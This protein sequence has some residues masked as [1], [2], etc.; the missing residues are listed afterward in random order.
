MSGTASITVLHVDDDTGFADLTADILER[1]DDQV[2]V[3]TAFSAS[4]GLAHL[5][6]AD[7]DCIVSDYDMPG[8]NGIDFLHAVREDYPDLPFILFTGKGSEAVASEAFSAGATDYLQKEG[9]TDQYT[10]LVQK[11]TNSVEKYRAEQTKKRRARA[12]E[13]ANEGIAIVNED[14]HYIEVNDAYADLYGSTRDALTGEHW[15]VTVPEDEVDQLQQHVF[16]KLHEQGHWTGE[17]VGQRADGSVYPKVFSL[18]L[19]DDGG[20]VCVVRD[21]TERKEGERTLERYQQLIDTLA[22][23]ACILDENGRYE[24]VNDALADVLN[25]TPSDLEGER[26]PFIQKLQADSANDPLQALVDGTRNELQGE[27][28][29]ELPEGE[30][31]TVEYRLRRITDDGTFD[32]IVAVSRD[33]TERKEREQAIENLH[34]TA[35]ELIMVE[36]PEQVADVAVDAVRDILDM[37]ANGVHLYDERENGLVPVAWTDW[38]EE[39][40]G[41]PP[42]FGPGEGI[43]WTAFETGEAQIY[44]DISGVS[45]RYNPDTDVRSEIVLPLDEHGVLVIGSTE[46]DAFDDTDVSL[47]NTL[48]THVTSALDRIEH[49]QSLKEERDFIEQA[50]DT[51]DDLFYVIGT[52]GTM[53]Q[54]NDH[55]SAVTGYTDEEL[56]DMDAVAFFPEDNQATVADAIEQT[57]AT[58]DTIVE[59]NLLTEEGEQI[60]YEFTGSRLTDT[61]GDV[62]GLIGIGRDIS[63]RRERERELTEYERIVETM[64][65]GVYAL[66][67]DGEYIH[68]NDYVEGLTGYDREEIAEA[69][70]SLIHD[71]EAIDQFQSAIRALLTTDRDIKTV[72]TQLQTADGREVPIETNLTLLPDDE[73]GYRGSVGVIRDISDRRERERELERYETIVRA[74]PDEVYTLDT[75][76]YLTSDIPPAGEETSISGYPPDDLVG[77]HVSLVMDEADVEKGEAIIQDLLKSETERTKS[78]EM[79]IV[80]REGG[81]IPHENHIALLPNDDGFRGTV[82]VLRNIADRKERERRLQRQNER[83]NEFASVVSHDLRNPLNVAQSRLEL[84]QDECDSAHLDH[85]AQAQDRMETLIDDLLMLARMGDRID[86][87]EA[88]ALADVSEGCWA[89]VATTDATLVSDTELTIEADLSRVKQLLENLFRNAIEHAGDDV[90]VT[91]GDL[92][93]RDGFYVADDGPGIPDDEREQ[94]FDT[95]Y[96]TAND[97]TGLGLNIVQKI[98]TAHGWDISVTDSENGGARFE[99][100]NVQTD[101]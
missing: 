94:V 23:W 64:G 77:E 45:N 72:E 35:R 13:T 33:I 34:S 69:G 50:L 43:A 61:D 73:G 63:D 4:D 87:T 86:E 29:M 42:T 92:D 59:A 71:D 10:V 60:P 52:D 32:G 5:A 38:A 46:P 95:G 83:L 82:G 67:L 70:P 1:G 96:S 22:E 68:L 18:A 85:I 75:E 9:G 30:S 19:L 99:I 49:E 12:M 24:V 27:H 48:A 80:T 25:S 89:T 88:V 21:I 31:A 91:V 14:G 44:G 37:P 2:T 100:T 84:V 28:T 40:V 55:V 47:A 74:F 11:I 65:D 93:D 78:F 90:T 66:D 36:T 98:T 81:R 58:G 39:I 26:S 54:W 97:G 76:G 17:I 51:L 15:T 62:I 7:I 8:M 20:H 79:D 41:E 16:P 57:L 56:A 6:E 3:E 53:R 101:R